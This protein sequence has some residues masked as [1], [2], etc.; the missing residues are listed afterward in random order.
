MT[1]KFN[2][3]RDDLLV[4]WKALYGDAIDAIAPELE[5]LR[6]VDP[7]AAERLVRRALENIV[8]YAITEFEVHL[9]QALA[10]GW[11]GK[12]GDRASLDRVPRR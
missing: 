12:W 6:Q 9:R 5:V 11:R 8:P 10:S 1:I 2:D 4:A 7:E 3:W